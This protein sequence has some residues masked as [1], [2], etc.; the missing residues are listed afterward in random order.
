MITNFLFFE[1]SQLM[2]DRSASK[3]KNDNVIIQDRTN[4][5]ETKRKLE[6]QFEMN[7][8]KSIKPSPNAVPIGFQTSSVISKPIYSMKSILV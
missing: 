7:A 3:R 4:V 5:G 2:T 8:K 6:K 1:N